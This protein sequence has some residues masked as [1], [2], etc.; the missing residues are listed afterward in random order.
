MHNKVNGYMLTGLLMKS[1]NLL[2]QLREVIY[3]VTGFISIVVHISIDINR[4][5][6]CIYL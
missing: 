5:K 1:N 2:D 4:Y 3:H 6:S